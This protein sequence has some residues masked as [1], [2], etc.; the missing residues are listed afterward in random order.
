MNAIHNDWS[1]LPVVRFE[2]LGSIAAREVMFGSR[3]CLVEF[4]KGSYS[5]HLNMYKTVKTHGPQKLDILVRLCNVIAKSLQIF[6]RKYLLSRMRTPDAPMGSQHLTK[7]LAAIYPD[8][9][10]GSCLLR[11]ICVS[12]AMRDAPSLSKRN[13][14]AKS[15]LHTASIAQRHY[16]LKFKSDGSKIQF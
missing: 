1:D 7:F 14:L 13:Q 12:N 8:T 16:E 15:M 4:A 5:L 3:N 2:D 10:L 9:N 11:K 6:P